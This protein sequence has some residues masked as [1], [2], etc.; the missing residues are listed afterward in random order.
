MSFKT[1]VEIAQSILMMLA[2]IIGGIWGVNEYLEKKS[3]DRISNSF[4]MLSEFR[5]NNDLQHYSEFSESSAVNKVLHDGTL[6]GIEKSEHITKLHT[7]QKRGQLKRIIDLYEN[8][9]ICVT[10]NHCDKKV[11]AAFMASRAHAAYVIGYGIITELRKQNN[12][13]NYADELIQIRQWYC[14]IPEFIN[15]K[16]NSATWCTALNEKQLN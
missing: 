1:K 16:L 4:V 2:L 13:P 12:D 6:N 14:T 3:Q 8:A 5:A 15:H 10:V 11:I 7:K 9:F